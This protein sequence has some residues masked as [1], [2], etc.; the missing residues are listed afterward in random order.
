MSDLLNHDWEVHIL[1]IFHEV[2]IIVDFLAIIGHLA[3]LGFCSY[4]SVP[5]GLAS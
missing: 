3:Q 1:F 4:D 2:S 5:N